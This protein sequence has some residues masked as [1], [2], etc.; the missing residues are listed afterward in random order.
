MHI[1]SSESRARSPE[2]SRSTISSSK[3]SSPTDRP[4]LK[5]KRILVEPA[6]V[7]ASSARELIVEDVDMSD[8][9][10]VV[11]QFPNGRH[12]FPRVVRTKREDGPQG[13][14]ALHDD[15]AVR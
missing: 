5:A 4:F 6:V 12:N 11:E 13:S 9:D 10:M 1:G 14:E 2:R 8:W 7:D 15:R 3:G